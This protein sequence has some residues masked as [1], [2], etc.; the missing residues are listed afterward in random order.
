MSFYRTYRPQIIED[1]DTDAVRLHVELLLTK[2]KNQLPH[3]YLFSGPKGT[4]KTSTARIIAKLFNCTN[5]DKSGGPC[6]KCDECRAIADGRY[7]DVIEMDAASNRGIDEIR[8]L[9]DSIALSPSSGGYKIFIIDEVHMLTQEAFNALLKTLEEPPIHAVFVLAT[10]DPQKIPA[11]IVS[12]CLHINFARAKDEDIIRALTRIVKI[13]KIDIEAPALD[14][15]VK[16]ADGSFRDGVKMLEQV[17]FHKGLISQKMTEEILALSLT[18]RRDTFL[19]H[20]SLKALKEAL[21]CIQE[22]SE[23]GVDFKMFLV[24]CLRTLETQLVQLVQAKNPDIQKTAT[25]VAIIKRLTQAYDELR[26]CPIPELP[27]ELAVVEYCEEKKNVSSVIPAQ[28]GIQDTKNWTPDRVGGDSATV[29]LITLDKLTEHWHDVIDELKPYNHS[30]AAVCRSARP[31]AIRNG[32]VV[33]EAFYKFHQEKL[34]EMKTRDM[35]GNVLK[36][37]FGEKVKVEVVLGKK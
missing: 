3:A 4:G 18:S 15:I 32:I 24:D 1:L 10:T 33:I 13:E 5:P 19:M 20:L 28:A 22:M 2:P 23:S 11:T 36:K 6:G 29:G 25:L 26:A 16:N 30:V 21:G 8:S 31:K 17:S 35:I 9:R 7:L 12:R 14:T 27:L 37:L 34:S